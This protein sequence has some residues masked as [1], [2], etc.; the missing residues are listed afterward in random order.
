MKKNKTNSH[1]VKRTFVYTPQEY[2]T[3]I[4]VD[5]RAAIF[6]EEI[7][8]SYFPVDLAMGRKTEKDGITTFELNLNYQEIAELENRMAERFGLFANLDN[9]AN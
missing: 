7:L 6:L 8:A 3:T 9:M 1:S 2:S 5:N 4:K